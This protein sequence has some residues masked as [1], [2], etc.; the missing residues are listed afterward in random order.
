[1]AGLSHGAQLMFVKLIVAVDD[2]GRFDA[3]PEILKGQ[4]YPL[5]KGTDEAM[6]VGW[7]DELC[8][9][10]KPPTMVY[11]VD[12]KTYLALTGWEAHRGSSRRAA[13]SKFP[14]PAEGECIASPDIREILG[15]PRY[16]PVSRESGVESRGTGEAPSVAVAPAPPNAEVPKIPPKTLEAMIAV[17]PDGM[18]Y[19][20]EDIYAWFAWAIPKMRLAGRRDFVKTARNWWPR[21]RPGEMAEAKSWLQDVRDRERAVV[22]KA[23]MAARP[24]PV[25]EFTPEQIE[26]ASRALG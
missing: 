15:D 21:I 12:G 16:P 2:Y 10:D 18:V 5:E 11:S 17:K 14:D 7:L 4:L 19:S 23:E 3:R 26:E 24:D 22:L 6:I 20:P 9:G 1:M 8:A 13:K 25:L